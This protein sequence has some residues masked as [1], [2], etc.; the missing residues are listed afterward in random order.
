MPTPDGR[1]LVFQRTEPAAAALAHLG[2]AEP[3]LERSLPPR[4][5][6]GRGARADARAPRRG[7]RRLARRQADRV[8]R[9]RP[10]HAQARASSPSRAARRA[11][12]A[13]TLPGFAYSPAWSPDGR[14]IAYSRWKPG[15]FRDI[16]VYD[17][18]TGAD[19]ALMHDRAMDVDPRFSPDGRTIVFSSDRTGIYNIFA[20]ELATE[21]LLPGHE[22]PR[23][24]PSSRRSRPTASCSSTWASPR[25]ATISS[26]RRSI[27]GRG[28]RRSRSR[29]RAPTRPPIRRASPTR[30]T[31]ARRAPRRRRSSRRSTAYKPWKYFYPHSW[32]LKLLDR[33]ARRRQRRRG[34]SS[35]SPTPWA[36]TADRYRRHHPR[37]RR[38]VAA[39]RLLVQ[40]ASG[41]RSTSRRR[42]RR[43]SRTTSSSTARA[44]TTGRPARA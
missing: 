37:R 24:A 29:T 10:R 9:G 43:C 40:P 14:L 26:R 15:G 11:C 25:R 23:A 17:L 30:P 44:S 35:A 12:S 41:R 4:P 3:Q 38:R 21:R 2:R 20:Y 42:A 32:V 6:D 5:R 31:P 36:T 28:C 16:H 8:H 7:A 22:P 19:R 1:A 27:P 34:V 13:A 39:L 18:A 33:S